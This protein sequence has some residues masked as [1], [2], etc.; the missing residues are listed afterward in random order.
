MKSRFEVRGYP[1]KLIEREKEK[2]KFLKNCKRCEVCLNVNETFTFT[3]TVTSE[4]YIINHKFS[5]KDEGLVYLLTCNCCKKQC[6]GKTG[7]EF[8]FRWNNLEETSTWL[9]KYTTTP[10]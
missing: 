2:V 6:V 8:R 9:N 5:C 3:S 1:N 4:T 7:D 10:T